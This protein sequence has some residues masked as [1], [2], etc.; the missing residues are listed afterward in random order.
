MVRITCLLLVLVGCTSS[1][2]QPVLSADDLRQA[3]RFEEAV[4]TL[5]QQARQ[6]ARNSLD[7]PDTLATYLGI[8][9]TIAW[10]TAVYLGRHAEARTLQDSVL[11]QGRGVLDARHPELLRAQHGQAVIAWYQNRLDEAV[12]INKP[13]EIGVL[14]DE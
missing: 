3:G 7:D 9:N 8:L 5:K 6:L 11:E 2:P 1:P 12:A 10:D 13:A 4:S 14:D